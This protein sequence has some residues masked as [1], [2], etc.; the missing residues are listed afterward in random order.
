MRLRQGDRHADGVRP[1][2]DEQVAGRDASAQQ[3]AAVSADAGV[4]AARLGPWSGQ[5]YRNTVTD[6]PVFF[7]LLRLL[8]RPRPESG[9]LRSVDLIIFSPS[10]CKGQA[11]GRAGA[12]VHSNGMATTQVVTIDSD[13]TEVPGAGSSRHQEVRQARAMH[14][15]A[16]HLEPV[17][18]MRRAAIHLHANAQHATHARHPPHNR[19]KLH[20]RAGGT[21]GSASGRATAA[22]CDSR[23]ATHACMHARTLARMHTC[24]RM[25]RVCP[26]HPMH[27]CSPSNPSRQRGS[28]TRPRP[29][30]H[31]CRRAEATACEQPAAAGAAAAAAAA[32]EQGAWRG[33]SGHQPNPASAPA[34]G[35]LW[36]SRPPS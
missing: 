9:R 36:P 11:G 35:W 14:L 17:Q 29:N 34:Q 33:V 8:D 3:R 21:V 19:T 20:V 27:A 7:F 16:V 23:N 18:P 22:R 12:G 4:R 24:A 31:T 25:L 2:H 13:D 30:H 32:A 5:T 10:Q 1:F 15:E 28:T 26:Q 6:S